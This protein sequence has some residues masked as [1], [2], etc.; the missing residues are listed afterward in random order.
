MSASAAL[1]LSITFRRGNMTVDDY[2][3][4]GVNRPTTPTVPP[5]PEA[6]ELPAKVLAATVSVPGLRI[7]PPLAPAEL[8][9]NAPL[10]I[11]SVP[12]L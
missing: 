1:W 3:G 4:G 9:V 10:A 12:S 7:D 2:L 5:P 11:A 8:F 6:A